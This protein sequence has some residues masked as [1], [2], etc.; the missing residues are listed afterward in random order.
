MPKGHQRKSTT[1]RLNIYLS[2]A[3]RR[4]VK[5]AAARRAVSISEYC[6]RAIT[7]QLVR[8][9]ERRATGNG[10]GLTENAVAAARRFRTRTF[11]GQVFTVSSADLIRET[12]EQGT[13]RWATQ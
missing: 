6:L 7:A 5:I 2:D 4:R 8:D 11:R 13:A 12:R 3:T 1:A 9:G 10:T